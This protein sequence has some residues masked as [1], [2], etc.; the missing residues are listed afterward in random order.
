MA[1]LHFCSHVDYWFSIIILLKPAS[2]PI[3]FQSL[4]WVAEY[5]S[6]SAEINSCE[7]GTK[8]LSSANIHNHT[9]FQTQSLFPVEVHFEVIFTSKMFCAFQG[10][11]WCLRFVLFV[12]FNRQPRLLPQQPTD[13]GECGQP[14]EAL[15]R[16]TVH[17]RFSGAHT[18]LFIYQERGRFDALLMAVHIKIRG[19]WKNN[20]EANPTYS[21]A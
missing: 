5:N 8:F 19:G 6:F 10:V 11:S 1:V 17:L 2:F 16:E 13:E 3:L 21:A 9:N 18:A 20:Q 4:L 14:T 12:R 15:L 7:V